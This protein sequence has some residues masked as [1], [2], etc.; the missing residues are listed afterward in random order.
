M[1]RICGYGQHLSSHLF[2]CARARA[3]THT[4]THTF[5]SHSIENSA[6]CSLSVFYVF[7]IFLAA[8]TQY[9]LQQHGKTGLAKEEEML[10]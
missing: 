7:C 4:H 1:T 5:S 6:L 8:S 3:R 9:V 10:I 2:S